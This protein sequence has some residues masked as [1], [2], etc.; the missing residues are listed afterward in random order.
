MLAPRLTTMPKRRSTSMM[1]FTLLE[2][3]KKTASAAQT[4]ARPS[5]SERPYPKH[6][7]WPRFTKWTTR[8]SISE[9]KHQ[10]SKLQDDCSR[11]SSLLVDCRNMSRH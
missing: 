6:S 8:V 5:R 4:Q 10:I 1:E 11:D 7:P 2:D 3:A 9:K